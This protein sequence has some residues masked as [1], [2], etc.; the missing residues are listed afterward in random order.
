MPSKAFIFDTKE[1]ANAFVEDGYPI[2][3]VNVGGGF[4]IPPE[5]AMTLRSQEP[6][7]DKETGKFIVADDGKALN[8]SG[9]KSVVFDVQKLMPVEPDIM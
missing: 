3:P 2:L 1:Q 6:L 8:K 5:Q 9:L 4:H 7:E